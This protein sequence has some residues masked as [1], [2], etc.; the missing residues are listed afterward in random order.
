MKKTE[1]VLVF[2][3]IASTILVY[4]RMPFGKTCFTIVCL[5]MSIYYLIGSVLLFNDIRLK[6]AFVR[7][8]YSE[9]GVREIVMSILAGVSL[10]YLMGALLFLVNDW[11]IQA[12]QVVILGAVLSLLLCVCLCA[13]FLI[14]KT[15]PTLKRILWRLLSALAFLGLVLLLT[16]GRSVNWI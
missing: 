15:H 16:I 12:T 2:L 13:V 5:I 7:N 11:P 1:R 4:S 10:F 3:L 9:I 14:I 8:A 6:L